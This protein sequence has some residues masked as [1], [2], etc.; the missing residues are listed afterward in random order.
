MN[1]HFYD[2]ENIYI[3]SNKPSVRNTSKLFVYIT[4]KR[5]LYPKRVHVKALRARH[6]QN[7]KRAH[8]SR[9][10]HIREFFREPLENC[11]K[12]G[13]PVP[14]NLHAKQKS[15]TKNAT[16]VSRRYS[17]KEFALSSGNPVV[18]SP[19]KCT[20]THLRVY[21]PALSYMYIA[22]VYVRENNFP[23]GPR[24]GWISI[25]IIL[26]MYYV[27]VGAD[28]CPRPLCR[29]QCGAEIHGFGMLY[30][31]REYENVRFNAWVDSFR[32]AAEIECEIVEWLLYE[33]LNLKDFINDV[34][35]MFCVM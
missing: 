3:Y 22:N 24:H 4:N 29:K 1:F 26:C 7:W 23:Q 12:R 13:S 20:T 6:G 5:S 31:F 19:W 9:E 14:E 17:W 15:K 18:C 21:S 27:R 32:R 16:R 10:C 8:K 34:W 2:P 35:I 25:F 28:F 33:R 30:Q 11:A